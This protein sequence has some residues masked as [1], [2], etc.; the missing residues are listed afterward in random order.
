M[1]V[2]GCCSRM[3]LV[4]TNM[5]AGASA[6]AAEEACL[7]ARVKTRRL[8]AAYFL[9]GTSQRPCRHDSGSCG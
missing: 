1:L 9:S 4:Y 5:V 3:Q 8:A 2:G 7:P 6:Q